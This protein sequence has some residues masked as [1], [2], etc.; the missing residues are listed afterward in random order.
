M[1]GTRAR[2]AWGV[3]AAAVLCYLVATLPLPLDSRTLPPMCT[4]YVFALCLRPVALL[5]LWLC[6]GTLRPPAALQ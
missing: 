6:F 5:G 1:Q 3:V 2:R 4:D